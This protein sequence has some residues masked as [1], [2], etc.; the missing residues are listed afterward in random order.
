M[1]GQPADTSPA[2]SNIDAIIVPAYRSSVHL[3]AAIELAHATGTFLLVL[4][5]GDARASDVATLARAAEVDG[6]AID[7]PR[8]FHHPL[9]AF[10]SS[11]H[12]ATRDAGFTDVRAKRNIG[13]LLA[14]QVGW[15]RVLF[16]D[17]DHVLKANDVARAAELLNTHR[18]AGFRAGQ[19]PDNSVVRHAERLAGG[20]PGVGPSIG[21]AAIRVDQA[22]TFFPEIYNEDWL[23]MYD[24]LIRGG[25]VTAGEVRQLPYDPF[26]DPAH[27]AAEEFGD[28]LAEGLMQ[29]KDMGLL[30]H[31][32]TTT[33]W[34]VILGRR[35]RLIQVLAWQL[36]AQQGTDDTVDRALRALQV[37]ERRLAG[38]SAVSL[39]SYVT[40]WRQDVEVWH[41]RLG[42]LPHAGTIQA[43]VTHLG[44]A[45]HTE[46]FDRVPV[47][48]AARR[49]A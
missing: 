14:R 26:A 24:S 35:A 13:L 9:L 46:Y 8:G 47:S 19:Y 37:A 38:I 36:S 18:I 2:K 39:Q 30:A 11:S 25:V 5:S 48:H 33:D 27:A 32:V 43:A 15:Q 23:F 40:T 31:E 7:L 16:S 44:L 17:D 34:S 42:A 41:E 4:C 10:A 1:P 3:R 12:P 22:T 45:D 6:L 21:S 49:A 28:V 20:Q 29:L